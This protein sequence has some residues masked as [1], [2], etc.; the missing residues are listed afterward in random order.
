MKSTSLALAL[1]LLLAPA[2]ASAQS[3]GGW[4]LDAVVDTREVR[5]DGLPVL[6]LTPGG[7][8]ERMGLATGDRIVSINGTALAGHASP[9]AAFETALAGADGRATLEVERAGSRLTLEGPL[10]TAAAVQGC[11]YVSDTDPTP[12]VSGLVF[13]VEITRIDGRSTPLDRLNRHRLPAGKHVLTIREIIPGRYLTMADGRRRAVM[14][15]Q[16]RANAYKALVVDVQPGMRY[17]IGARLLREQE[18]PEAIRAN[19]YW[20]PVIHGTR[21]EECR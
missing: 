14:L 21:A 12:V 15:R 7:A 8:A 3:S 17:Q 18:G 19:A 4:R 20:E 5:P 10:T 16:E 11:G 13:P 6:A 9:A 1:L 2:V